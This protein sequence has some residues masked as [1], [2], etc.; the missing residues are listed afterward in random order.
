MTKLEKIKKFIT[1]VLGVLVFA[2]GVK[3]FMAYKCPAPPALSGIVFMMIGFAMWL[4]SCMMLDY[5]CSKNCK[6]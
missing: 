3:M 5:L 6:K 4:N 1:L 2:I